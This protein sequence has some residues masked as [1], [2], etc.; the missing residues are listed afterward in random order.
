[1]NVTG[2]QAL[3]RAGQLQ[4]VL[5]PADL[6]ANAPRVIADLDSLFPPAH[7]QYVVGPVVE[8]TWGPGALLKAE[9]AI[10]IELPKPLRIAVLGVLRLT[11]PNA[12][13]PIADMTL[14]LVG[15]IDLTAKTMSLDMSLTHSTLASMPLTGQA[16]LRAGW[17]ASPVFLLAIGGFNP[18]FPTPAGFPALDRIGLCLGSGNLTMRLTAYLAVTT[19]TLQ[20]GSR[21]DLRAAAGPASLTATVSFDALIQFEPFRLELDLA[22]HAAIVLWGSPLMALDITAHLTGPGPWQMQGQVHFSVLF[23]SFTVSVSGTFGAAIA[24]G[25]PAH[26]DI[27]TPLSA[28]VTDTANWTMSVPAAAAGLVL[29]AGVTGTALHPLGGLELHQR[30]VPLE[31]RVDRYGPEPLPAAAQ[32]SVTAG[33]R[34][35]ASNPVTDLFAP[36]Q[37]ITMSDT[38]KLTTPSFQSLTSGLQ[39]M[40]P[41]T[42]V[43]TEDATSDTRPDEPAVQTLSVPEWNRNVIDASTAAGATVSPGETPAALTAPAMRPL[44]GAMPTPSAAVPAIAPVG[45]LRTSYLGPVYGIAAQAPR[46]DIMG[47]ADQKPVFSPAPDGSYSAEIA[48]TVNLTPGQVVVYPSEIADARLLVPDG[49]HSA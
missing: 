34:S 25:A 24:G 6:A 12:A 32:F 40:S 26:A 48:A 14:D 16:A 37:Y 33:A 39:I 43:A 15:V 29:R 30:I 17:G 41:A 18:H 7:G 28:A 10:Y 1:M 27:L 22:I 5:F 19:N 23:L 4:N 49:A 21:V 9:L 20:L 45:A 36:A 46:Y 2:L 13:A 8:L 44:T 35:S 31:Q 42:V 38:R 47:V 11:A 3:T